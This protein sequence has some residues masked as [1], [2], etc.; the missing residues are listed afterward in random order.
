[1]RSLGEEEALLPATLVHLVLLA[2][3]SACPRSPSDNTW[4]DCSIIMDGGV[5][6][7]CKH[8]SAPFEEAELCRA[9]SDSHAVGCPRYERTAGAEAEVELL[10]KAL[11]E[12]EHR[13]QEE[14]RLREEQLRRKDEQICRLTLQLQPELTERSAASTIDV[15]FEDEGA[16][17]LVTDELE[18]GS[19]GVFVVGIKPSGQAACRP[20]VQPGMRIVGVAGRSC[21]HL[22]YREVTQ[23]IKSHAARPLILRFE[24]PEPPSAP[25]SIGNGTE[26]EP[27]PEPEPDKVISEA[28]PPPSIP[29]PSS[30]P[31]LANLARRLSA[32]AGRVVTNLS[33]WREQRR[34]SMDLAGVP[35]ELLSAGFPAWKCR[36]AVAKTAMRTANGEANAAFDYLER[37]QGES[38]D[39]WRTM[40]ASDGEPPA[41]LSAHGGGGGGGNWVDVEKSTGT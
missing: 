31:P 13:V 29:P 28:V 25:P 3:R 21:A 32:D 9:H 26:V 33:E 5:P 6:Y 27:E 7:V 15:A 37:F 19:P 12:A 38:D 40:E 14:A 39:W 17:G 22:R 30:P 18:T 11:R 2:A 34:A 16:L 23:M 24:A 35:P 1:M 36:I 4:A 8:C 20:Q 10:R 41:P